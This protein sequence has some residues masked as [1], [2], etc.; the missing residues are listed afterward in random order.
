MLNNGQINS[1]SPAL[2]QSFS[3]GVTSVAMANSLGL[4]M[5]NAVVAEKGSQTIQS[6]S[7]SQCCVLMVAVGAAATAKAAGG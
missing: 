7:I 2:A 5:E 1:M 4:M 3:V 6:A